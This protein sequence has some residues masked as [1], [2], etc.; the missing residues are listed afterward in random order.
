MV[1]GRGGTKGDPGDKGFKLKPI[2]GLISPESSHTWPCICP[3]NYKPISRQSQGAGGM[4]ALMSEPLPTPSPSLAAFAAWLVWVAE[5]PLNTE[6]CRSASCTYGTQGQRP[7][8]G[9]TLVEGHQYYGSWAKSRAHWQPAQRCPG[10]SSER[11]ASVVQVRRGGSWVEHHLEGTP[12]SSPVLRTHTDPCPVPTLSF[13][14][15][16]SLVGALG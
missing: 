12:V 6:T 10:A 9:R 15:L 16:F 2:L 13:S 8:D 7:S 3:E 11:R 14:S 4:A 1:V 5:G